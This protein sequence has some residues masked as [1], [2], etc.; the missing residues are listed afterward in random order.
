MG[1]LNCCMAAF[2]K[3]LTNDVKWLPAKSSLL[4]TDEEVEV[5][6]ALFFEQVP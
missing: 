5:A 6:A 1:P 3:P 2:A 4:T